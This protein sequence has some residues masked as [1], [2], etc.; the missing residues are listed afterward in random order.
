MA[1]IK[2]KDVATLINYINENRIFPAIKRYQYLPIDMEF[3]LSYIKTIGQYRNNKFRIDFQ[4]QFVYENIVS[5]IHGDP[6]MKC[7]SP[8]RPSEIISGNL[9]AGIYIAGNT[10]TGKS[11]CLE[12][13]NVY[14]QSRGIAVD[15]AGD[16][17]ALSW[18]GGMRAD[19]IINDYQHTG[20]Y[21][22]FTRQPILCIQDLG[23]ESTEAMYMGN[24]INV[25]RAILENRG[26]RA[27]KITLITSN[28]PMQ[29]E[30]TKSMYGDRV[31]SR[32]REMCNYF[33]L[34][35]IDRRTL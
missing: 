25:M 33:E 3:V 18:G 17:R 13:L 8:D 1:R 20:D 21:S 5:W 35:G 26:D 27:D 2:D 9:N 11:W 16:K 23:A 29:H 4:N 22:Q 7:M 32:L 19:A 14:A 15:I 31:A 24:R 34:T 10:G 28:Y 30:K 12:I 6:Q